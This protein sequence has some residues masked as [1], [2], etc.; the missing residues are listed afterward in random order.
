MAAL[1]EKAGAGRRPED[2]QRQARAQD[3]SSGQ[4]MTGKLSGH[5]LNESSLESCNQAANAQQVTRLTRR[6]ADQQQDR[7]KFGPLNCSRRTNGQ[8]DLGNGLSHSITK[9]GLIQPQFSAKDFIRQFC[10]KKM[11]DRE[12]W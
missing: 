2:W 8:H 11:S 6:G 4:R 5:C 9:G 1:V 12:A 7:G 10:P 3:G